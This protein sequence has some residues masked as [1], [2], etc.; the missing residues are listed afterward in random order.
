MIFSYI[1]CDENLNMNTMYTGFEPKT[2][3]DP[4]SYLSDCTLAWR[5]CF[6]RASHLHWENFEGKKY[7]GC[8]F[9]S[10]V[11]GHVAQPHSTRNDIVIS[12]WVLDTVH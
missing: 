11:M 8:P 6:T 1:F 5:A 9:L 3:I 4:K 10:H 12:H 2:H 7:E